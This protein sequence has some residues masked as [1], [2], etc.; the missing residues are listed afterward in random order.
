MLAAEQVSRK[1]PYFKDYYLAKKA[2]GKHHYVCLLYTSFI[3][4][5]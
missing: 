3:R 5:R 2:E 4:A 1:D